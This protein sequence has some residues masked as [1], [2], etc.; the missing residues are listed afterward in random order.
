[1]HSGILLHNLIRALSIINFKDQWSH[2]DIVIQSKWNLLRLWGDMVCR[3]NDA[4][5]KI[6]EEAFRRAIFN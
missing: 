6:L 2:F 3:A 1:M 5:E 4:E